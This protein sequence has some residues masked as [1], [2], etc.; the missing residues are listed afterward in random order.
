MEQNYQEAATKDFEIIDDIQILKNYGY[1]I[2]EWRHYFVNKTIGSTPDTCGGGT[3]RIEFPNLNFVKHIR[4]KNLCKRLDQILYQLMTSRYKTSGD[5]WIRK[6]KA[7]RLPFSIKE[8]KE[9]KI[10]FRRESE[11]Y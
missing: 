5:P 9:L 11:F 4:T 10:Q 7:G 8:I 6:I 2:T 1:T 3:I